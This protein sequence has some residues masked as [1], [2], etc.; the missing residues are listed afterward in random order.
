MYKN[1]ILITFNNKYCKCNL[2]SFQV[3]NILLIELCLL[4]YF[5]TINS[6]GSVRQLIHLLMHVMPVENRIFCFFFFFF[7]L[8]ASVSSLCIEACSRATVTASLKL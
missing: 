3:Y 5:N 4:H 7:P 2:Q 1:K 8:E 6:E